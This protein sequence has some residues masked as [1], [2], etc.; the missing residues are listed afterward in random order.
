MDH[1]KT[2]PCFLA[3]AGKM[4]RPCLASR[5]RWPM[6]GTGTGPGTW[7]TFQYGSYKYTTTKNPTAMANK[8]K[9]Y[10]SIARRTVPISI[11]SIFSP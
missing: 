8:V 6:S 1:L 2:G 5:W 10:S 3:S 7:R 4:S 9:V 11:F